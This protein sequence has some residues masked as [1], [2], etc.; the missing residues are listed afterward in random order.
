MTVPGLALFYGGLV[1]SKNMLSML[2]QVFYAVVVV[3]VIYF[4]YGYSL[5]FTG[6]SDFIG[7]FSKAFLS[8][9]TAESTPGGTFSVGIALPELIFVCFQATFA[10]IT[11]ALLLGATAE[12]TKFA[13]VALFI[14][15][16]LTFVYFPMAHMVWYWAGPD[17][18][19]AAAKALLL[20]PMRRE[21]Q[22]AGGTR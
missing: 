2:M 16:W 8:G 4:L 21:D 11:A 9:V 7:G 14:P 5:A 13:A 12:R 19:D 18:V 22:A 20:R 15:L 1:R 10:G 6:G 3:I 17:A